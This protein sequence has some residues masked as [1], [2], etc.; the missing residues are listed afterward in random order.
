VKKYIATISSVMLL[1]IIVL[2]HPLFQLFKLTDYH[3]KVNQVK[4]VFLIEKGSISTFRLLKIFQILPPSS[5]L[6]FLGSSLFYSNAPKIKID[7]SISQS[8]RDPGMIQSNPWVLLRGK[9][10]NLRFAS[11]RV[12]QP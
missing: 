9:T 2:S 1:Q 6:R 8:S 10:I 5:L 12:G 3:S 4:T 11:Q 7:N